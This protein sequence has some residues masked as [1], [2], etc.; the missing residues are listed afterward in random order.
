MK[1]QIKSVNDRKHYIDWLRVLAFGLLFLFHSWRPFDHFPWHIKNEEQNFIF[2]LLTMFTHG[3]RMH[4]IFLVSGAGTWFAMK[5]R[6]GHICKRQGEAINYSFSIRNS[7]NNS[8]TTI[9]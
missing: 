7:I 4:L 3:W 5:S 9:L 1:T 2:D 6:K 8:T